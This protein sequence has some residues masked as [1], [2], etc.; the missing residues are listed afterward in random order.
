M[1]TYNAAMLANFHEFF[2]EK[3]ESKST[4]KLKVM[5]ADDAGCASPPA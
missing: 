5:P 3:V 4:S 1:Q 2:A